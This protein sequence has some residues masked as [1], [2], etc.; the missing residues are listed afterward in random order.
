[1]IKI[2]YVNKLNDFHKISRDFRRSIEI[3][4]QEK[5]S[6]LNIIILVMLFSYYIYVDVFGCI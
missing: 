5:E 2:N 1:M 4:L 6:I 3:C